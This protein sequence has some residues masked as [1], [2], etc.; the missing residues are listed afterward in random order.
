MGEALGGARAASVAFVIFSTMQSML[1]TQQHIGSLE[2]SDALNAELRVRVEE[3]ERQEAAVQTLNDELR[4]QIGDRSRQLF[5]ALALT[6]G[7]AHGVHALEP[8]SIVQD[9]YRV[10]RELGSGAMGMVYEAIRL[11]DEKRFALKV[12][13]DISGVELARLAREAQIA[14][15]IS[16]PNVVTIV[17]VDVSNEGFLYL[18]L[19]Y[20]EGC[21]LRDLR[22]RYEDTA[23]TREVLTQIA[24]GLEALHEKDIVHRDLKPANV[25]VRFDEAERPTAKL[26]DFGISRYLS[27][28]RA[29]TAAPSPPI[30][31]ERTARAEDVSTMVAGVDV[32]P[33]KRLE[34]RAKGDDKEGTS[35]PQISSPG[36]VGKPSSSSK[37][38]STSSL[39]ETGFIAGTP[40]YIAP[41]LA[42]GI[43][44]LAPA[45]DLFSFGV[46]AFEMLCGRKPFNEPPTS[47]RLAGRAVPVSPSL[48]TER[49]DL[50]PAVAEIL[51][52]CLSLDP[53]KRPTAREV[54]A[55]LREEHVERKLA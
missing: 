24:E 15:T 36:V 33:T 37:L 38:A 48:R 22:P 43:D 44:A 7:R 18:V 14:A 39:T 34:P 20:I 28:E 13:R 49:P 31:T 11:H 29:P 42:D 5:A 55:T 26:A 19:E 32:T 54:V 23:F 53:A 10:V 3:L 30:S 6:G 40:M 46:L 8:G 12:A 51:S 27:E 2:K 1:L 4:R 45:V 41:E 25:L 52:A 16:H 47:L 50:P 9:R 35:A 17:D 21:S